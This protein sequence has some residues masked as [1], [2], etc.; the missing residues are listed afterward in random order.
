MPG[1]S[2][3]GTPYCPTLRDEVSQGDLFGDVPFL[4]LD[5]QQAAPAPRLDRHPGMLLSHDCEYDKPRVHF[6][7]VARVR[8]LAHLD[9]G[10]RGNV[11]GYQTRA[12]FYLP[13]GPAGFPEA[14]V[15]F[16]QLAS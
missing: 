12:T 3:P 6:V 4:G 1:E 7:L 2:S 10:S 16:E 14:F 13:E 9:L 5:T 11:R 15:D 8:P